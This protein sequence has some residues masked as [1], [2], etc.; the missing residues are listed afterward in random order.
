MRRVTLLGLA[1]VLAGALALVAVS[2]AVPTRSQAGER[3]AA[4]AVHCSGEGAKNIYNYGDWECGTPEGFSPWAYMREAEDYSFRR[5]TTVVRQGEYSG[6]FE[7]RPGDDPNGSGGE[8]AE[9]YGLRDA[10]MGEGDAAYYA[11][12]IRHTKQ[13]PQ[14]E[15]GCC[16]VAQWRARFSTVTGH[17]P[18]ML[19]TPVGPEGRDADGM[20]ILQRAGTCTLPPEPTCDHTVNHTLL[21]GEEFRGDLGKWHDWI[22]Y[23]DWTATNTGQLK[24]WHRVEGETDF[25]PVLDETGV[26][27]LKEIDGEVADVYPKYGI[28]RP[29]AQPDV[30]HVLYNDSYCVARW[31]EVARTCLP[32]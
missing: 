17:P 27:T 4:A 11:F 5:S 23:V 21:S 18:L 2:G 13:W 20:R 25:T 15:K 8:R 16:I 26:P 7:V 29:T 12:S 24:V 10:Q 28:Y 14:V 22:I 19:N 9:A 30:T 1:G 6:R 31:F 3:T 32:E